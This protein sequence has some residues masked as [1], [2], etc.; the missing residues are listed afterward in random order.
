[1][2][3]V[4]TIV[5]LSL[6][7]DLF[8][9]PAN[10]LPHCDAYTLYQRLPFPFLCFLALSNGTRNV[11]HQIRMDF[12]QQHSERSPAFERFSFPRPN[13]RRNGTSSSLVRIFRFSCKRGIYIRCRWIYGFTLLV[14]DLLCRLK[15]G[16]LKSFR[17]LQFLVSPHIGALSDKYGRKKILLLT[18]AGNI[19][20][21]IVY[22]FR[23]SNLFDSV[24]LLD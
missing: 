15:F 14:R 23:S 3:K 12:S 13:T 20:S 21:A 11:K 10:F 22:D 24:D 4:E 9:M 16:L 8:G 1:M 7:L 6:V 17:T 18:M 19:L 5:F 2:A